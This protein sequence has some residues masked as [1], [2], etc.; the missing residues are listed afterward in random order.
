M[1]EST[2]AKIPASRIVVVMPNWLGDAV[3]ATP[4]LRALRGLY[5][6]AHVVA[7]ARPLVA[8]VCEGLVNEVKVYGK[9]EEAKISKWMRAQHF[10]LGVLLPNSFRSAWT[11][12]RGAV[13]RR[14]GYARGGRS[15]LVTD[16]VKPL[17]KTTEQWWHDEAI[18]TAIRLLSQEEPVA[19][20]ELVRVD[21]S[22]KS[23]AYYVEH[24]M[25]ST[26]AIVRSKISALR[27][28]ALPR[29]LRAN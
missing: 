25:L 11:M 27:D 6:Q 2:G 15:L 23:G 19:D 13:K 29:I 9:K 8:P 16:R 17:K 7:V 26:G 24:R 12:W 10:D 1:A 4:F 18:R 5:P 14:L 3:M 28:S 20:G 22:G 21:V